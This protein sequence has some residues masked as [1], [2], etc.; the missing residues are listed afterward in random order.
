MPT[1]LCAAGL[2]FLAFTVSMFVGLY[3]GNDFTTVVMRSIAA[4]FVFLVLGIVLSLIGQKV[5][6]ENF[7]REAQALDDLAKERALARNGMTEAD[8]ENGSEDNELVE[9]SGNSDLEELPQVANA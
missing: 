3:V 6:L 4:L 2:A 1:Q 8:L 9:N 5:V 7:K